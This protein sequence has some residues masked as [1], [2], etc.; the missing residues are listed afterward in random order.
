MAM[1]TA[2]NR[3][4]RP[5]ASHRPAVLLTGENLRRVSVV[6]NKAGPPAYAR[7]VD[8]VFIDE[9]NRHKRL[10]GVCSSTSAPEHTIADRS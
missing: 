1:A 6:R 7:I 10:K 3:L 5:S 8:F 4:H 9:Q 2:R